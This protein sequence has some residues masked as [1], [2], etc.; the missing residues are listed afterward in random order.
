[1]SGCY[2]EESDCYQ[3]FVKD[4]QKLKVMVVVCCD[5]CV[6]FEMIF[7]CGLG[8]FFVVC[9]VVNFVLF[10][11]FDGNYYFILVVLEFV[12]QGL[13]ICDI[14][15]MGYGCCGGI[16]V[17]FLL[18]F[19]LFLFGD[20]IGKWMG[21]LDGFVEQIRSV[22]ILIVVEWQW[23]LEC[24]LVCNFFQ[25]FRIFFCVKILEDVGKMWFYGVWFDILIG[26]FWIMDFVSGDFICF[27][28]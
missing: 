8:E 14:V 13:K 10:Y 1:M 15:V 6:V 17:V 12:V 11:E 28:F 18:F 27:K 22:G 19:E 9:N 20:F 23:V 3:V 2:C 5:F 25:N 16:G 21:L 4:G 24:V 7:D 26:E